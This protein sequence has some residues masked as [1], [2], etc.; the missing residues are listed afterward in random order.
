MVARATR[1]GKQGPNWK[2]AESRSEGAVSPL[3]RLWLSPYI[4]THLLGWVL[5]RGIFVSCIYLKNFTPIC[6]WNYTVDKLP[7]L[8]H[9]SFISHCGE[10]EGQQSQDLSVGN[11]CGVSPQIS[12]W[13]F[14]KKH[15]ELFVLGCA[16]EIWD[17]TT[18]CLVT[19]GPQLGWERRHSLQQ[20][21]PC[22]QKL[23]SFSII[24]VCQQ[25]ICE[26]LPVISP[27]L[28]GKLF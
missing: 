26:H 17:R 2:E 5:G 3:Q 20:G 8:D 14:P 27:R 15:A 28:K 22:P 23:V 13:S 10:M 11:S 16:W 18:E 19:L 4:Y 6:C 25:N 1:G 21:C 24:F 9:L 12:H 7:Q